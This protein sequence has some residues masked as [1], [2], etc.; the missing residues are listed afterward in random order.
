MSNTLFSICSAFCSLCLSLFE[1]LYNIKETACLQRNPKIF[2]CNPKKF[3]I[4]NET[5]RKEEKKPYLSSTA[6]W[7]SP[8][9]PYPSCSASRQKKRQGRKQSQKVNKAPCFE[10]WEVARRRVLSVIC[11]SPTTQL[12]V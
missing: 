10:Y 9:R 3:L 1:P 4:H 2:V 12:S 6:K 7:S 5:E 11:R 8:V